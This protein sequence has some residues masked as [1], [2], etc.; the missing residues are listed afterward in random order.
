MSKLMWKEKYFKIKSN[1]NVFKEFEF[2]PVRLNCNSHLYI[3]FEITFLFLNSME[4]NQL[5]LTQF[6]F[7][8]SHIKFSTF[9]SG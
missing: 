1:T 9:K 6:G 2:S 3:P 5:N 4:A 8:G 7:Q